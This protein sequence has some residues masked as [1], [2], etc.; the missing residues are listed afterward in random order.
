[1]ERVELVMPQPRLVIALPPGGGITDG[2]LLGPGLSFTRK[3]GDR[4]AG[5]TCTLYDVTADRGRAH[6][7]VCLT[8]DGL[9]LRGEGQGRDGRSASIEAVD[10]AQRPQ[11]IG[12]FSVPD[13][14][15]TVNLP[16]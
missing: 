10:V 7:T 11:P 13:G 2:F 3:G 8:A 16:Q 14:Y 5:R 9:L 12:L 4:V 6:G 1:M 15:R